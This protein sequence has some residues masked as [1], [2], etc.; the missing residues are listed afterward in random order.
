MTL[1]TLGTDSSGR[2]IRESQ[3]FAAVLEQVYA[4]LGWRP[5]IT[6]GGWM[7]DA[8]AGAS[9]TTHD[10]DAADFRVRNLT[11][12]QINDL[13]RVLRA[14][15]IAAWLR[16][17]RHGGFTDPHVHAVPGSWASPS[18]SALRQWND[19]LYGRDGLASH[20][21]DYHPYPLAN[22]PPE[23]DMYTDADR[24][25]DQR[26]E[27]KLDKLAELEQTRFQNFRKKVNAMAAKLGVKL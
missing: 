16:N 5:V 6:Q 23:D 1:V 24:A 11:A 4:V 17:A 15:G 12:R 10:K 20:G 26:I 25:R 8:A 3:E 22:T 27:A 19:C 13:V 7:G 2:K 9:S 21:N 14:H 18:P